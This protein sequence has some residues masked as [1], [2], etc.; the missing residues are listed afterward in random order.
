MRQRLSFLMPRANRARG[1]VRGALPRI[2]A[3]GKPP[4]K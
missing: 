3:R 4:L 2:P 1:K